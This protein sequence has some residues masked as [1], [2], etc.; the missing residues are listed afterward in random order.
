MISQRLLITCALWPAVV[1]AEEPR[2]IPLWPGGAPGFEDR[3]G[4]VPIAK[5]Y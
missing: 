5:D 1:A 3:R 2:E 4:E